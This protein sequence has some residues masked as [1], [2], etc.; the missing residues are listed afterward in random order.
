MTDRL[1]I[2]NEPAAGLSTGAMR[3]R[4]FGAMTTFAVVASK[5]SPTSSRL[6]TVLTP[7]RALSRLQPG[8]VALGR[9]DVLPSLGGVKGGAVCGQRGSRRTKFWLYAVPVPAV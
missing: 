9:L 8:D 3:P 7:G 5:A 6:G 2:G 4:S 1:P